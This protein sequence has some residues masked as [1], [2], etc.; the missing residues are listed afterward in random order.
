MAKYTIHFLPD[1]R[2]A[3]VDENTNLLDAARKANVY[4]DGICAGEGVC[5]KCRVIVRQGEVAG[6]S[7]DYLTRDEILH[8]YVLACKVMPRSNMVLE[9]PPESR[10]G[11]YEGLGRDS[12]QFRDF[13]HRGAQRPP[14]ELDPLVEKLAL[15]LPEPT[16]DDPTADQERLLETIRKRRPGTLQ[17]G[18]KIARELPRVLRSKNVNRTS[19]K[20]QWDGHV[21]ATVGRRG[22]T[23]EVIC[24]EQGNTVDRNF[25]LALDVGTTTVVAHLVDLT[26]GITRDAA[27]KYNSQIKYGADVISRINYARQPG[28]AEVLH[29]AIIQDIEMLIDDLEERAKVP[30]GDISCVVAA[31]NTAML[32]FL[33]AL[34]TDLIRISPFVP[35]TTSPPPLRA[36]EIGLRIN[37]R[38]ILYTLP[39]AGSYVGGDITAGILAS[40]MHKSEDIALL[41]DI[42]TNGE[43]VLGN[44]DFLVACSA[45]AGPAFE[46]GSISC[47]MRATSGAIDSVRISRREPAVFACTI[48]GCPPV[49]LC[50]TGLIDLIAEMLLAGIVDRH[51]H[52]Q[53]NRMP[54]RFRFNGED[55]RVKFVLIG[56]E[57]SGNGRDI[58]LTQADVENL[59]RTKGAIY[60]AADSLVQ[61]LGLSF[62]DIKK[63]YIAG[64]FGN[65]LDVPHCITIGLLPDVPMDRIE[66][67]GNSSVAGAKMV[68]TS[69]RMCDEVLRIR[70]RITYREL[71]VD[72]TYMEQFTSACFLPHTDLSRFPSVLKQEAFFSTTN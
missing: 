21:T 39:M 32:H 61:G 46:G 9:V 30:R 31:G 65:R 70:D 45:S 72:P 60:A 62:D 71:I 51:G 37:P 33:L 12:E 34:E 64:A 4:V 16:I 66:F 67:I 53:V 56:A 26:S 23:S 54:G 19:W 3:V 11:G 14:P 29:R 8:G 43:V 15:T 36:A 6:E 10:L 17:M 41:L 44:R 38:G 49:G 1:D 69:R 13:A 25:G 35:A 2:E 48:D 52:F 47:G 50:G 42:G 59:I 7:T 58:V 24:V 20:W 68:M 55:N 22:D 5:G 28:G 57:E 18:L 40:G 63:I 27:A